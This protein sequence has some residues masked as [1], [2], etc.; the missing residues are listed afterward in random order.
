MTSAIPSS[1]I[2]LQPASYASQR[3]L[4]ELC[5]LGNP[6]EVIKALNKGAFPDSDTLKVARQ[7]LDQ[8]YFACGPIGPSDEY[9]EQSEDGLA[10]LGRYYSWVRI[11]NQLE[12]KK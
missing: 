8:A 3:T 7:K 1:S 2:P 6:E 9:L 12:A 11:V 5:R 10:V 4:T